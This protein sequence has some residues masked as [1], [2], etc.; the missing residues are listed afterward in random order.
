[1]AMEDDD[2][3]ELL[4]Y[5]LSTLSS[6][7][8]LFL[9]FD[10]PST[11]RSIENQRGKQL[12]RRCLLFEQNTNDLL[13]DALLLLDERHFFGRRGQKIS[14]FTCLPSHCDEASY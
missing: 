8:Q 5:V 10:K 1:M 2:D 13:E 9:S 14:A 12:D 11:V 3:E 6:I 7:C 4:F